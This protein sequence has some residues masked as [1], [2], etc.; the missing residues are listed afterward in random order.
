MNEN[1]PVL[2]KRAVNRETWQQLLLQWRQSGLTAKQFCQEHRIKE[3]DLKRWS[4]R[5]NKKKYHSALKNPPTNHAAA[6][7]FI[8]VT[9]S[10]S[11]TEPA[12][13]GGI[14]IILGKNIHLRLSKQFDEALLLRLV[15]T[16]RRIDLC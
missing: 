9:V 15:Y 13:A 1:Q 8:P 11:A 12:S 2:S 7:T 16:L 4:Y 14:D 10:Q 6:K 3:A 5:L